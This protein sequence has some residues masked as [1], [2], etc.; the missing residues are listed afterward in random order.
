MS[1]NQV[2][3]KL[4]DVARLAG[5][6]AA[7]ASKAVNGRVDVS[8]ATRSRVLAAAEELGYVPTSG[9]ANG[10]Y[11]LIALVADNLTSTYTLDVLRGATTTAMAHG[12]GLVSLYTHGGT[13]DQPLAPLADEWFDMV[14]AQRYVGVIVVTSRLSARQ[15]AKVREV[16]IGLVAID[17]ANVM[18]PDFTSIGATN[19]NGGVEATQH[20]IDLGHRRIGFVRGTPGSVP[21][22]ERLQGYLSA[23]SMNELPHDPRLVAGNNF[24]H[25]MGLEAGRELLS[26]PDEIR[27]S[28]IFASCDDAAL[29]VF[30]AARLLGMSVPQDVS[31][32][33]FDDTLI[34]GL[35]TP[36]LTT[37]R[38]PLEE[39][40]SA[41][42]RALMDR[43]G[44][45]P[46]TA[47][48]I[49]LATHLVLRGSTAEAES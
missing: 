49:R 5:V 32:V 44:G 33:G 1:T 18:P 25:E 3:V 46:T 16:G 22:T 4:D 31:V 12:A 20:L 43:R 47:G 24:S 10:T 27:P 41:A 40:G 17:P 11:P 30:E 48:P 15:L 23:L 45:R 35:A 7:T 21:A 19:W 34:A 13:T 26:L 29:G 38:Q 28:A 6:S 14:K 39:M 2:R 37:V 36:G 9:E 8:A 42:V